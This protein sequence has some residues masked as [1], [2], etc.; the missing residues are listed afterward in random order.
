MNESSANG[1]FVPSADA[2]IDELEAA[3]RSDLE[4][5]WPEARL[6]D[7]RANVGFS[8]G[9]TTS[10][11]FRIRAEDETFEL[12]V[13]PRAVR[14]GDADGVIRTLRERG[15][16]ELLREERRLLVEREEEGFRVGPRPDDIVL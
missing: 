16:T 9:K 14:G 12:V 2:L 8:D 6:L 3:L 1:P 15:W 11:A 5:R 4:E 7:R 13:G 10:H